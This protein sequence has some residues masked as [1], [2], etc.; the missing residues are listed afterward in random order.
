MHGE[1]TVRRVTEQT[2]LWG[3]SSF[4]GYEIHMG[5][6]EFEDGSKNN[7]PILSCGRVYGT[8]IHGLF[9][10]DAFRHKFLDFARATCGLA[11]AETRAN[12][13]AERDARI[14]RWARHLCQALDMRMIREWAGI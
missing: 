10:D 6:T 5:E 4:S 14:D 2:D 13:T 7:D 1:K 3:G 11:P 8:Y 12:V 9:D